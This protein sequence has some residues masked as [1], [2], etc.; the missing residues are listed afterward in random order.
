MIWAA[1]IL[2]DIPVFLF[3]A[4]LLFD[5][6]SGADDTVKGAIVSILKGIFLI[7]SL[8]SDRSEVDQYG[9][10]GSRFDLVPNLCFYFLCACDRVRRI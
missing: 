9:Y 6:K 8:N 2:L 4:W 5:D 7:S 10:R 3:L 1:F